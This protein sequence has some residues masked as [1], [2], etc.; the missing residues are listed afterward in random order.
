VLSQVN[1]R[2]L[3]AVIVN[4]TFMVGPYDS[5][6]SSGKIILLGLKQ[7]IQW[8]PPGGKNFVHVGDVA[9]GIYS[10][11]VCGKQGHCYLLAG[12]NLSYKEFFD[13]L[14]MHIG[15]KPIQILIPKPGLYLAGVFGGIWNLTNTH[16]H[17]AL[18]LTNAKLL[19]LGNYY[20][21]R[22]AQQAFNLTTT[23]IGDAI[24]D[25]L[26]WFKIKKYVSKENYS[27]QGTSFDR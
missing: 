18:N 25:A 6:P 2:R 13:Q 5:K 20:T 14:N 7:G 12:E 10:A 21:G 27:T 3:N 24:K 11:L 19:C 4:P 15:R 23:P 8:Y 17:V 26:E 9:K 16:H 22:K 1:D